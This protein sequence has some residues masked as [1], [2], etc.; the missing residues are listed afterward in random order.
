LA[1]PNDVIAI[2]LMLGSI[3]SLMAGPLVILVKEI[4]LPIHFFVI[5]TILSFKEAFRIRGH[6]VIALHASLILTLQMHAELMSPRIFAYFLYHNEAYMLYLHLLTQ[7]D[8]GYTTSWYLLAKF[9]M[10]RVF[11]PGNGGAGDLKL[12][13]TKTRYLCY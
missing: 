5:V 8:A 3:H 12:K 4:I 1:S 9:Q 11:C 10:Y 2:G 13:R 7:D 6:P